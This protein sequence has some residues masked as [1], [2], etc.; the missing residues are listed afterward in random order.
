MAKSFL[1]I[2]ATEAQ[3]RIR[4]FRATGWRPDEVEPPL[5]DEVAMS[6]G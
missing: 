5:E 2:D 1:R 6:I 4:C 3:L